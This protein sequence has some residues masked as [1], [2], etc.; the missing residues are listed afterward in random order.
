MDSF[1]LSML[2]AQVLGLSL[3]GACLWTSPVRADLDKEEKD[4]KEAKEARPA[5][6]EDEHEELHHKI[7]E[8][9]RKNLEEI[10]RLLKEIQGSLGSKDTSPATQG[11]QK[12]VVERLNKLIAELEK[13]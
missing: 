6:G 8:E 3:L 2:R 4:A 7:A 5:L 13:G 10:D 1:R 9:G 12:E 11:R